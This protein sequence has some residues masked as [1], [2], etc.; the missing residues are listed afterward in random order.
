MEYVEVKTDRIYIGG[1]T[2]KMCWCQWGN[3]LVPK[4]IEFIGAKTDRIFSCQDE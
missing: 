3:R 4:L 1:K 2:D